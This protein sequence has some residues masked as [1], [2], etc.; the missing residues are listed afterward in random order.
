MLLSIWPDLRGA[1]KKRKVILCT[2]LVLHLTHKTNPPKYRR[3]IQTLMNIAAEMK[4]RKEKKKPP[5]HVSTLTAFKQS[6]WYT[7]SSESSSRASHS[8][9][10]AQASTPGQYT[11]N[12]PIFQSATLIHKR[13]ILPWSLILAM[14]IILFSQILFL[15]LSAFVVFVV[16]LEV[17]D[18]INWYELSPL[19]QIIECKNHL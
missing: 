1:K 2:L 19:T 6:G 16:T 18:R 15:F 7:K 14:G 11:T 3:K 12:S 17:Y 4:A 13:D 5:S 10:L 8:S 9:N